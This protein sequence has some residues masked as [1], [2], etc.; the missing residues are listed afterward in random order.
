VHFLILTLLESENDIP[1]YD[2]KGA[3]DKKG[4]DPVILLLYSSYSAAA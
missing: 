1:T 3:W 4:W 2:R